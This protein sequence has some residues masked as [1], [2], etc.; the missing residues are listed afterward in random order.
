MNGAR[1]LPV[2]A[3]AVAVVAA[4]IL[5]DVLG[6]ARVQ[7]LGRVAVVVPAVGRVGV[8]PSRPGWRAQRVGAV[9]A[10]PCRSG[11]WSWSAIGV[12]LSGDQLQATEYTQLFRAK[13]RLGLR[14]P[15]VAWLLETFLLVPIVSCD[16][17]GEGQ[18]FG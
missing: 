1:G 11:S 18:G 17:R 16:Q 6:D 10:L 13:S 3:L 12:W 15:L 8:G 2:G 9:D 5:V 7:R 4:A 14:G